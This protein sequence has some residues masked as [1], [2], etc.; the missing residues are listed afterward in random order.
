MAPIF[1]LLFSLAVP[2]SRKPI[3]GR[4][5]DDSDADLYAEYHG[6]PPPGVVAASPPMMGHMSPLGASPPT[7]PSY[8]QQRATPPVPRVQEARK[9]RH[10]SH[11]RCQSYGSPFDF[12]P[13][14]SETID[15]NFTSVAGRFQRSQ[16][17]VNDQIPQNKPPPP[18]PPQASISP[19]DSN[20]SLTDTYTASTP[21]PPHS[22]NTTSNSTVSSTVPDAST[23]PAQHTAG[24]IHHSASSPS[25]ANK[26]PSPSS[27][28]MPSPSPS[29]PTLP[30]PLSSA[31]SSSNLQQQTEPASTAFDFSAFEE[32]YRDHAQLL[33]EKRAY[34]ER[35]RRA[36]RSY[37]DRSK[38]WSND[39]AGLDFMAEANML[40]DLA[41]CE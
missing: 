37:G 13:D 16:S 11:T 7:Q 18:P 12:L 14:L 4:N 28:S 24:T 39:S 25:I 3:P 36:K 21:L 32:L 41:S 10:R 19:A 26:P 40:D 38:R 8:L 17:V 9:P 29:T 34:I 23:P 6:P 20:T 31:P 15:T 33:H 30:Q 22:P 1:Y 35:Q 27:P 2:L 5:I